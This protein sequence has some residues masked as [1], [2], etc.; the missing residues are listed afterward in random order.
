MG[1]L[2]EITGAIEKGLMRWEFRKEMCVNC[3]Y[4]KRLGLEYIIL[5]NTLIYLLL[6]AFIVFYI[7]RNYI[8][9]AL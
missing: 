4:V 3:V 2:R 9:R 1:T 7:V 6:H 8:E 5:S